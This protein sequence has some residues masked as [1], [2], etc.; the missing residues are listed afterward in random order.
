M[1]VH[2]QDIHDIFHKKLINIFLSTV[3]TGTIVIHGNN[4][5][6]AGYHHNDSQK[7]FGDFMATN[8]WSLNNPGN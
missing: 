2:I 7:L 4:Q 5:Q 3:S 1:C 6:D 8:T